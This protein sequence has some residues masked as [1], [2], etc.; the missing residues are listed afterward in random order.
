MPYQSTPHLAHA[1]SKIFGGENLKFANNSVQTGLYLRIYRKR[2]RKILHTVYV[3][4]ASGNR[5]KF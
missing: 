2:H 3:V 4:K 1:S 5:L